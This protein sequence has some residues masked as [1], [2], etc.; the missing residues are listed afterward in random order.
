MRITSLLVVPWIATQVLLARAAV[1]NCPYQGPAFAKPKQLAKSAVMQAALAN[2]TS[3]INAWEVAPA[4][5]PSTATWSVQIFAA[6]DEVALWEHHHASA[7]LNMTINGNTIYRIGSITKVFTVLTFLI[8]AGD[9]YWNLPV[10]DFIPEL[11]TIVKT[12]VSDRDPVMNVDWAHVTVGALASQ[13]AGVV[14]DYGT[15]GELTQVVDEVT[16]RGQGFPPVSTQYIPVCGE[17]IHCTRKQLFHGLQNVPPSWGPSQSPG[18]SDLGYALVAYALETIANKNFTVMLHEDIINPLGMT[19]T[20]YT[21]PPRNVTGIVVPVG[22]GYGWTFD[23]GQ[24]RPTG[25]M[26]SSVND[27]AT[28]GRA[29]FNH[30]LITGAL[31]RRWFKPA[32]LTSAINDGIGYPWGVRRIP[33]GNGNQGHRVVDAFIK[34]GNINQYASLLV[35][36]PDYDVG[37]VILMAGGMAPNANWDLADAIGATLLPALEET[38]RLE[39]H[40]MFAGTYEDTTTNLNSSITLSTDP[41]RPGLGIDRWISN[42]TDMYWFAI[43]YTLGYQPASPS[44]RLYP[45]GLEAVVNGTAVTSYKAV[46]ED[47]A[48][49]S[50][51]NRT[52]STDCGSWTM[53]SAVLYADMP[54]DQFI[55]TFSKDGK[56]VTSIKPLSLRADLA[57]IS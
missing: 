3:I 53:Q 31:T 50:R 24:A 4:N 36:I 27:I 13:M 11:A 44:I 14:K 49:P 56:N 5:N 26:Y 1:P 57:K 37:I 6:S 20:Y 33:M 8:E 25:N 38:A 43:Q 40:M 51:S 35:M 9:K 48:A 15:M 17:F 23:L 46:I 21:T 41:T 54:L 7:T 39:S 16:L 30:K 18:Y 29:I 34:S 10:I 42:G 52:F 22:N 45:T 12:D 32:G 47:L 19:H 55:F 28:F 2:L